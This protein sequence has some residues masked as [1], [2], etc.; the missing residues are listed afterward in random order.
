VKNV[1]SRL[2]LATF[3]LALVGTVLLTVGSRP[4]QAGNYKCA[5]GSCWTST[6]SGGCFHC[7]INPAP[8]YC[9]C[10]VH[11]TCPTASTLCGNCDLACSGTVVACSDKCPGCTL[12][13]SCPPGKGSTASTSASSSAKAV[14]I[15]PTYSKWINSQSLL[16]GVSGASPLM[17]Q[18][19]LHMRD[20][21]EQWGCG[22]VT[23]WV[24]DP[25]DPKHVQSKVVINSNEFGTTTFRVFN[26]STNLDETLVVNAAE[27]L[28][29]LRTVPS[30]ASDTPQRTVIVAHGMLDESTPSSNASSV[31]NTKAVVPI[32]PTYSQWI[33]SQPLLDGVS[34]VSPLMRELVL[35]M[36]Q[37]KEE[38]G[39]SY[40]TGLVVNPDDPKHVQS[41]VVIHSNEFGITTF[42]IFDQ[43][44]DRDETLIVHA[45][46]NMWQLRTLPSYAP[47]TPQ[48]AV[49]LASGTLDGK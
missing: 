6:F 37:S 19:V 43:A 42:T 4:V 49:V 1:K 33:N 36:R 5:S 35:H 24:V 14:P 9:S 28:W 22:Y 48:P 7:L 20:A 23:G 17:K 15:R 47:A 11:G 32:Q 45:A 40:S 10:S 13:F 44:N 38:W 12:P 8:A 21:Q 3:V 25:D 18:L 2:G 30:Y 39:V 31:D 46:K 26:R 34:A 29:Q 16:D 27:H 41:K